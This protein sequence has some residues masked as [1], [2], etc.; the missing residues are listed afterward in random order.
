MT[1][2][3]QNALGADVVVVLT[4]Q[5]GGHKMRGDDGL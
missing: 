2:E 3:M 4:K 1:S 5:V